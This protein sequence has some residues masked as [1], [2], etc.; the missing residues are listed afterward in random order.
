MAIEGIKGSAMAYQAGVTPVAK[1]SA[2]QVKTESISIENADYA[3][4]ND[5]VEISS[6]S[7]QRFKDGSEGDAKQQSSNNANSA[8]EEQIKKAVEAINK[9][10]TNSEAIFGIHE[11][12]NRITIKLVDKETK[13]TIKEL[14]PE[15]TLDMIAKVWEIAGLLVDEKR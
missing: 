6:K 7:N 13:E 10:M 14:P 3:I 5:T 2:Q 9:K 4:S 11:Q 15:K 1:E 12:T 8:S